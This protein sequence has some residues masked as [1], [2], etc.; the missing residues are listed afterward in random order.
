MENMYVSSNFF[1]SLPPSTVLRR[2]HFGPEKSVAPYSRLWPLML[3]LFLPLPLPSTP[4]ALAVSDGG[5]CCAR[6]AAGGSPDVFGPNGA[7]SRK[8]MCTF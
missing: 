2:L 5:R 6:G 7:G 4:P 3:H 8:K 1:L